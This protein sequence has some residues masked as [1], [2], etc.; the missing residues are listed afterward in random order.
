MTHF[1]RVLFNA[2]CPVGG[3]FFRLLSFPHLSIVFFFI[4]FLQEWNTVRVL[5]FCETANALNVPLHVFA[6]RH[7]K[8]A[9]PSHTKHYPSI[10]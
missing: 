5:A 4:L 8:T 3:T 6:C 10:K 2:E 7:D 9:S 1:G